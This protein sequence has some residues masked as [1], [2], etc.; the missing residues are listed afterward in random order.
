MDMRALGLFLVPCM[1]ALGQTKGESLPERLVKRAISYARTNG[2]E[3][4][5]QQTNEPGG[6]F[7]VGSGSELYLYI[8]DAKGIM[9]ANGFKTELVGKDR[10]GAKDADGKFFVREML[11]VTKGGGS[12]WVDYKYA[13]P[14]DGKIELKTSYVEAHEGM[15]FCCGTYKK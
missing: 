4:L 1:V 8:Y 6:V 10:S 13:N 3:K 9:K 15:I 14:K 2:L 5:I 12:G 7:H 11:K